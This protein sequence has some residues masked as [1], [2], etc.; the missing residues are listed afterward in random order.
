MRSSTIGR[1]SLAV[2]AMA[3]AS[4]ITLAPGV[5]R[6]ATPPVVVKPSSMNGWAIV[7]DNGHA[8]GSGSLVVGPTTPPAGVGSA[9]LQLSASNAGWDFEGAASFAGTR[10]DS[11]TSLSYDTYR[12]SFDT[13]DNLAIALQMSVDYD[14]TDAFTAFQGRLVFEP[15]ETVPG[16]VPQNTW[17]HWD[18]TAG[19]W[20][21]SGNAF[22][23]GVNVGKA[24]TQG[25]PCTWTDLKAD[26]PNAGIRPTSGKLY[27]KA[28]SGWNS[29]DGNADNLT[30]G[31]GGVDT[32]YD[33]EAET[34]CTTTCYV[35]ATTGS[36]AFGGGTAT[37]AKKTIQAAINTVSAD[38]QVRVMPGNY[39]EVAP[40]SAPTTIGATYQFGLFFGSAKPGISLI[41]V[42]AADVAIT[43]A[44]ATLATITTNATNNF[45]YDGIFIEAANTTIQGVK[46]G[47]NDAGDNKTIEVVGD[48]FTLRNATTSIPN[49]GGSIYID[50]FS[51]GGTVVKSY[52]ILDNV[53]PDG[54]SIA[55]ASGAGNT[56]PVSGREILGNTFDLMNNGFNAISFNG[57]G[58]VPWFVY[59]V[60]GAV[61]QNNSF[62]HSTQYIRARGVYIENQFDWTSYWNDNTFDKAAVALVTVSPFDVRTF[63][64][65]TASGTFTNVRRIGGSIQG[66]LDTAHA[67][68]TVLAQGVFNEAA[69]ITKPVSLLGSGEGQTVLHGPSNGNGISIASGV[70]DVTISDLT[71]QD[72]DNGVALPGGGT[73][74]N[75]TFDHVQSIFN[76]V[77]GF[78]LPAAS[79]TNVNLL[80]VDASNNGLAGSNGRG[81][82]FTDGTKTN[83]SITDGTFDNNNLVGIDLNDGS[84][85]GVTITGN[86]VIGNG[87]SGIG[88][89]GAEGP[90]ANLIGNNTVTNNGRFG[91]EIKNSTGNGEAS[92]PGSL[93]VDNNTVTRT[94]AATN[95]KD[96]AGIA[97][98]RRAPGPLNLD[99]PSGAVLSANTVSG[100]H[101]MA[102]G[103]TGDGFGIV[104]EGL[105]QV[106]TGNTVSDNDVDI[107]I[108]SNNTTNA[109][110]TPGF[111]RGDASA[112]S[113]MIN[114]NLILASTGLDLRN[115]GAPTTD[116]TCNAY[117]NATGPVASKVVGAFVTV[118]FYI[119]PD[120]TVPCGVPTGVTATAGNSQAVVS[121]VAP[122]ANSGAGLTG[123][124]V[125]AGPGGATC[126]TTGA[127][128]CTVLGLTNGTAY[129]FT[130]QAINASGN[131]AS[132]APSSPVTPFG[133]ASQAPPGTPD[134]NPVDP[135]RV[136]DTRPGNSPN[137]LRTV[138]KTKV[139]GATVLE[140]QMTGL[141][142]FVPLTGVGAVS[143]NI[144]VTNPDGAGFVTAYPCGTRELV[145]NVNYLAG[146]T[147]ANAAIVPVSATGTVCFFSNVPA[148]IVVD[149]NGWLTAGRGF[150]G[151]AP[152]RVFDTR[153]ANSPDALRT[154]PKTP[155]VAGTFMTVNVTDIAGVPATGAGA[156]TLNVGVTNPVAGGFITVYPCGTRDFVSNV[157]FAAGQTVS[158]AVIATVSADGN[159]CFYTSATTDLV[160]DI[161]G[162][163]STTSDFKGVTPTRM[164]DTRPGQSPNAVRTV[165]KAKIGGATILEVK[166][167]DIAGVP[168]TGLSSVS[169]N[170]A[171][172]NPDAD[173]FV[174]AYPCGA[175]NL[176]SSVNY[177]TGATVSNAVLVPVSATGTVCF[178]SMVPTDIVVD[179]N[180]WFSTEATV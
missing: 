14:L 109:Q 78:F 153:P 89:L 130:V 6:A 83:V 4:L 140:V 177:T 76:D 104:V 44:N 99:Q 94:D 90:G 134:F 172:A 21:Q 33:F 46:I 168:A 139:G 148:D 27:L 48:N 108:Q 19:K 162:W 87:D 159:V 71:V 154:V 54:T 68:D 17:Q 64:Y 136:F 117:D 91:I 121:W 174:T 143:L 39:H 92:G 131:G 8:G 163:F 40:N 52:H 95:A 105:G 179:L 96:Y 110:S 128:T 74:S 26:Y 141:T 1:V 178:F 35:D 146:Q 23:G 63:T 166:M 34:P 161:S 151:V 25:S 88:V 176:I 80:S 147:V 50:D 103:S 69:N 133:S 155:V 67:G 22:V 65:T 72:F 3:T 149:I 38:G 66:E 135:Q 101:R 111:D 158:N 82:Y 84:A 120:M 152:K 81:V 86:E 5:T 18:T 11:I 180:G 9:R 79:L 106:V 45:G 30:I 144:T 58:G 13:G 132:S 164:F 10:L 62:S 53:F 165:A 47:P 119:T 36:D 138:S 97:V 56:G 122:A 169:L 116:A 171:V 170:V 126:T 113:A 107:Q 125:T 160:V 70:N 75:L 28:G 77:H 85:T 2:V 142:G 7:D 24:C 73:E 150:T 123:Y 102:V 98:F 41:G 32:T 51:A 49:G 20:W 112:S 16:A 145:A 124:L 31:V 175:R 156:V 42:T 12:A 55:I 118:P 29:F 37:S 93:V 57:T 127:L 173:G 114:G 15:Y 60:G 100:Y 137:A 43:D 157:N 61:I 115:V 129:T 167:T 59:P